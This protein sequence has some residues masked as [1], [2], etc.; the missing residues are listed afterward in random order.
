MS[1]KQILEATMSMVAVL[2]LAVSAFGGIHYTVS[3]LNSVPGGP[4]AYGLSDL[5][6]MG[7]SSEVGTPG[8][9]L[10]NGVLTNLDNLIPSGTG[11]DLLTALSVD[12]SNKQI[13]GTGIVGGTSAPFLLTLA[14]DADGNGLV[15]GSDLSI[16]QRHFNPLGGPGNGF[17]TGDFNSDGAVSGS[18][19]AI[20]QQNF[21]PLGATFSIELPDTGGDQGISAPEPMTLTLLAISVGLAAPRIRRA[22]KR[23]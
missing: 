16:W 10:I 2:G 3:N 7:M 12:N 20:W 9:V 15:N 11:W 22:F 6:V 23:S 4:G 1:M 18:D 5:G 21:N 13:V 19:L 14:G 17:W 8:Q